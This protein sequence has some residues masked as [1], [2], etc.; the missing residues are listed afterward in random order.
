MAPTW[1]DTNGDSDGLTTNGV[2]ILRPVGSFV[3]GVEPG[4]WLEVT[5]M[6]NMRKRR[7]ERSSR[8]PNTAVSKLYDIKYKYNTNV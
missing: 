3:A 8:T 1:V 6:G 7:A 4:E 2:A 5:V